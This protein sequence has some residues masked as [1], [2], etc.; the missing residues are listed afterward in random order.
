MDSA[1]A[2]DI[3]FCVIQ[4]DETMK[5]NTVLGPAPSYLFD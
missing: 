4:D 1:K 3:N 2:V 5:I